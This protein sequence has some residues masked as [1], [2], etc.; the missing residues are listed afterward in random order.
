MRADLDAGALFAIAFE[1]VRD[2]DY[3]DLLRMCRGIA[4][5]VANRTEPRPPLVVL[6]D[7]DVGKTIGHL[8]HDELGVESELISIDGV[9]LNE[10]DFVDVGELLTPPG[11]IPLVIKSLLFS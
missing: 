3:H 5:S 6:V 8:L 7:G 2:P 1:W 4:A 11:V 9:T 10:L